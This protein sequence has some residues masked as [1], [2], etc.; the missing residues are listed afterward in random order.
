MMEKNRLGMVLF[1]T[2][3]AIFFILLIAAYLILHN[4]VPP[5]EPTAASSLEPLKTGF[6]SLFL[7]ASSFTIW[8]AGKSLARRESR[9]WQRWLGVT[10]LLGIIFL[11]GQ[12]FEWATLIRQGTTVS[13]D[14]FGTTFFTMTG[15]HGLH[16]LVGLLGL[17][18]L[19]ALTL[20]GEFRGPRS[21]AV[22]TMSLYWHFVDAVWVV[23]FGVTYA[24]LLL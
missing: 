19:L 22:E 24:T 18:I 9:Q 3:E 23:I 4:N 16:V 17:T 12:G 1:I 7:F 20:R 10:I 21:P 5:G 11:V 15:F 13:R 2:S 8:R 14:T 6:F